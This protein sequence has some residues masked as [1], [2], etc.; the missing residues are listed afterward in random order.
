MMKATLH[1]PAGPV[2]AL[3]TQRWRPGC[4]SQ[5]IYRESLFSVDFGAGHDPGITL[6]EFLLQFGWV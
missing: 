4:V 3:D 5:A 2:N 1:E 6:L